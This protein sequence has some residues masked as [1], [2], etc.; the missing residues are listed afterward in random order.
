M[1]AWRDSSEEAAYLNS[2][3]LSKAQITHRG[4]EGSHR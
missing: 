2:I 1:Q 4:N 3:D